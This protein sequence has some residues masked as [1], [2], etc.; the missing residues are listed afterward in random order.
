MMLRFAGALA[1][2]PLAVMALCAT[3]ARAQQ[4]DGSGVS[5]EVTTSQS[6][7]LQQKKEVPQA[8][9]SAPGKETPTLREVKVTAEEELKQA[10]GVSTITQEDIEKTPPINDLSDIIRRQ[11]GVN[12][13]GNSSSGYRGNNR[14]I[15]LRG[16]GPENTLI[17]IDG[18]PVMSRNSVR[19][20]RSGDRDTRGDTNWVPADDVESIEVIRGPAAARYGSGAAGGVV[21]IITKGI[22]KETTGSITSYISQPEHSEEGATHRIGFNAAGPLSEQ[23]GFR[24]YGN[25]NKTDADDYDINAASTASSASTAAGREG[26]INKDVAATLQWKPNANQAVDFNFSYSRQSNIYAGDTQTGAAASYNTKTTGDEYLGQETNRMT[27]NAYSI[28][29]RGDWDFGTSKT[30]LQFEQTHNRR[31][32]E[33]LTGGVDGNI[34][35][36]SRHTSVLNNYLFHSEVSMPLQGWRS[37]TLTAGI[38]ASHSKLTDPASVLNAASVTGL[39]GVTGIASDPDDRSTTSDQSIAAVFVE[40]NIEII[41]DVMLTPGLRLDNL[42]GYGNNWSPSLNT[43]YYIT[44]NW[45]L[46][47]GIARAFK[48]P[49]LYQIDPDYLYVSSGSG[50]NAS[51]K[52][53]YGTSGCYILGNSNL[54]PE[55]SW[56]KEIGLNWAS[57]GWNAGVT[58]FRNDYDSKIVAGST[59]L[60][61]AL[62]TAYYN[63]SGATYAVYQWENVSNA[64]VEGWEGNLKVPVSRTINWSNNLTYMVRND[65][66]DGQPLSVIP[67][68]T[69]NTNLDWQATEKLSVVVTGTFYGQQKPRTTAYNTG[70]AATGDELT[71]VSPYNIW[72]ISSGYK[73]NQTWSGRIGVTNIFDKRKYREGAAASAGA[74]TYN[75]AGRAYFA[76]LTT[77]F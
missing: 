21:N 56:N 15:D 47:G 30:Y 9:A 8:A 46:K 19:Y 77:K 73:F 18:K 14:Q 27:R 11:P 25:Y 59:P 67:E 48:A 1:P 65:D 3:P 64:V 58:W 4:A 44:P 36:D 2:I 45:T 63:G 13:T 23:W 17:L 66:Q 10:P 70:T 71:K 55:I 75:E 51:D 12:L 52:T 32:D 43:S 68:F 7:S 50:C 61:K 24:V 42:S 72:G 53:A 31:L 57:D 33:G 28:E 34:D 39:S 62:A 5:A 6:V 74:A 76:M 49:N 35:S 29:H 41:K 26:V 60:S 54:K 22:P 40:D 37:Q 69:L 20:G 38:E 16:M